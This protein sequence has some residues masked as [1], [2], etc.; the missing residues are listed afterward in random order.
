[1]R[2]CYCDSHSEL[3]FMLAVPGMLSTVLVA[4]RGEIARRVFR[5]CRDLGLSTVAVYPD[6]DAGAPYVA[7]AYAAVRRPGPAPAGTYLR[8][9]RSGEAARR[10][11]A[12]AWPPGYVVPAR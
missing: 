6:P 4:N 1:M 8:A 11:G 12:Y 10:Y 2:R 9:D 7:Q 5:S 3:T